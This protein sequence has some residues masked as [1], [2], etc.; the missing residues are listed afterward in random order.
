MVQ[1]PLVGQGHLIIEDSRYHSTPR[2]LPDKTQQSQETDIRATGG[3]RTHN[4]SNRTASD[5]AT[6]P[7]DTGF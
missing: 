4:P 6:Q 1:Q 2:P 7:G 5:P 3:I